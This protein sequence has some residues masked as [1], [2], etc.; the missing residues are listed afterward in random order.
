MKAEVDK[1][2]VQAQ[3]DLEHLRTAKIE[4]GIKDM[5]VSKQ[6]TSDAASEETVVDTKDKGKGKAK[7]ES[8]E[9]SQ[10]LST[11]DMTPGTTFLNRITSSTNQLQ[12]A[13][14]S[15]FQSTLA[16]ASSNP[17]MSNP[18]QLRDQLA[19]NL[20]LSSAK[21]NLQLSMKQ[22]EKMA[23]DYLKKGDQWIKDAEKWMGDAVKVLPPDDDDEARYI[24]T[25]WDAGDFYSF[26]TSAAAKPKVK[27]GDVLFD[28]RD[29]GSRPSLPG[30][31]LAGSRKEALLSRLREDKDL[32]IVDPEGEGESE[33]RRNE[34]REWV[35]TQWPLVNTKE[36][37]A[38]EDNIGTIRMA[39]GEQARKQW[40]LI[41]LIDEVVPETLTD[42]HFWQRYLFHKAMIEAEDEKRKKVLEGKLTPDP[43]IAIPHRSKAKPQLMPT[44][45]LSRSAAAGRLQLG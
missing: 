29:K 9:S 8:P 7:D 35:K 38:E 22:A 37:E 42:E 39:L 4:V 41:P 20:R 27:K 31:T 45:S 15:T 3:A 13:L 6:A 21:Q 40:G 44:S 10:R 12:H 32:L 16:S 30:P 18:A 43:R 17:A 11:E 1:T 26:S 34:F 24:A 23:E 19:E 28:S 36:R 5:N 14:Q 33:E 25:G 2:V